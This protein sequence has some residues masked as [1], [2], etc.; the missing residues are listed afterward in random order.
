METAVGV[1]RPSIKKNDECKNTSATI[2]GKG[3]LFANDEK[4]IKNDK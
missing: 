4:A 2:A 3:N 1:L